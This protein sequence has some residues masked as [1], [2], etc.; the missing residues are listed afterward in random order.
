MTPYTHDGPHL[1]L[2]RQQQLDDL[3][4]DAAAGSDDGDGTRAA[5][6]AVCRPTPPAACA[7]GSGGA[8]RQGLDVGGGGRCLCATELAI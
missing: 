2:L 3:R 7:T 8:H 6:H 5:T 4:T 1:P